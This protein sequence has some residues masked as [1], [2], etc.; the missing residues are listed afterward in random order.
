MGAVHTIVKHETFAAAT[1]SQCQAPT[2]VNQARPLPRGPILA[3]VATD[4][5]ALAVL[6]A[7]PCQPS[8]RGQIPNTSGERLNQLPS[9]TLLHGIIQSSEDAIIGEDPEGRIILWNPGASRLFGY[10]AS[11]VLGKLANLIVP[12]GHREEAERHRQAALRGSIVGRYETLRCTSE[13]EA[14]AVTVT[15]SAIYE[16]DG[17][18]IGLS[19]IVRDRSGQ[20]EIER[21]AAQLAA[22]VQSSDDAIASKDLNGVVQTWNPAAERLFGYTAEEMV[23]QSIRRIIPDD[24]WSEED[25]VLEQVRT[26]ERVE[27]FETLRRRKDGT[28][29]PVSITVSPIRDLNGQIIGASKIARDLSAL[30]AYATTLEQTVRERTASLELANTQL[31]SFA[32]SV[33]HD[34]R[35]PLRGMHGLA[36]ALLADYGESLDDR[37]RDYARRIVLEARMLDHLIQDLL[38]YSR[39]TRID[40]ALEA[41]DVG[42]VVEAALHNLDEDI[43]SNRATIEVEPWLPRLRANRVVLVQVL[44]NLISNAVKFGGENPRIR[45]RAQNING[46]AR[47][48]VEDNGIGIAP[49]HHDRIFRAFERLHGVEEYPGTGI[50]LAIV[51]K[52][53][54]RLGGRIGVESREGEGSRFWFELPQSEAA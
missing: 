33:S 27:H 48:W 54:E 19:N 10:T 8:W 39:L 3:P 15:I 37:A 52:A 4:A 6:G 34:L 16:S 24:R 22:L 30:R 31:E 29:I 47:I 18:L 20:K 7:T 38:E 40:V 21:S 46:S 14:R 42:E 51:H 45:V 53:I 2:W 23:G 32:Y 26:G 25:R 43:R 12:V 50:G 28:L 13:G 1:C 49:K 36:D 41:V 11:E 17:R 35:A 9:A 44:T 5:P